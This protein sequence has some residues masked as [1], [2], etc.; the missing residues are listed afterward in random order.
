M[1]LAAVA[2]FVGSDESRT[3]SSES[4][5]QVIRAALEWA[6]IDEN[7]PDH[8]LLPDPTN[9]LISLDDLSFEELLLL[10]GITLAALTEQELQDKADQDG[11]LMRLSLTNLQISGSKAS[12]RVSN[13]WLS[14]S[15]ESSGFLSGGYCDLELREKDGRWAFERRISC[16]IA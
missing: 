12:V 3:S 5:R 13:M 16:A 1:A 10:P 11:S 8:A 9:I 14:P 4:R 2:W 15:N 7:V 6:L